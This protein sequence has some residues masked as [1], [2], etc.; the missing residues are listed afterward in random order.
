MI[1]FNEVTWY[2]KLAAVIFFIG[3]LPILIFYIG[4]QYEKTKSVFIIEIPE[5][6]ISKKDAINNFGKENKIN[7]EI[8]KINDFE[9]PQIKNFENYAIEQKVNNY[10]TDV[11]KNSNCG[12][13]TFSKDN[14]YNLNMKVSY[15]KNEIFSVAIHSS[16]YCSGPYPTNDSNESLTFDMKNGEIVPFT[17]LFSNY[18]KDRQA[19]MSLIFSEQIKKINGVPDD[20][21]CDAIYYMKNDQG[22]FDDYLET[23]EYNI[24]NFGLSGQPSL[25][26]VIES[27]SEIGYASIEKL[28]PYFDSSSLLSRVK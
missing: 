9:I 26:H 14:Y 2:S 17:K 19:I 15:A 24:E 21:S 8:V 25:P 4:I 18:K 16:W 22:D 6:S 23:I 7:Y 10:L 12:D 13:V 1:K 5:N 28:A 27:C 11:A 20:L 3:V